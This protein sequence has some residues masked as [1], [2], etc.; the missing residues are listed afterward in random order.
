MRTLLSIGLSLALIA[1]T[2]NAAGIFD[3]EVRDL[4]LPCLVHDTDNYLGFGLGR[5]NPQAANHSATA[6]YF[7]SGNLVIGRRLS[8]RIAIEGNYTSLGSF[9]NSATAQTT[10]LDTYSV[11]A[12][13]KIG[14]DEERYI[15]VFG[16]GGYSA[17]VVSLIPVGN[18][19]HGDLTY[20]AG[21]E[22]TLSPAVQRIWYVRFAVDRFNVGSLTPIT[23]G[24]YAPKDS[25]TNYSAS[26]LFNF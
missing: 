22:L 14:L 3:D 21:L 26:L 13:G 12:V 10:V 15:S 8:Q 9:Y 11:V 1:N 4:D 18:A 24:A 16:R 25:V 19:W 6:Q 2:S 17:T 20:G 7:G 23:Q 5:S